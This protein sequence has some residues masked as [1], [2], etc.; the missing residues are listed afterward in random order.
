MLRMLACHGSTRTFGYLTT[1]S[2]QPCRYSYA[3]AIRWADSTSIRRHLPNAASH[4]RFESLQRLQGFPQ[5]QPAECSALP[6]Q[7]CEAD[8][9]LNVLSGPVLGSLAVLTRSATRVTRAYSGPGPKL[10]RPR[11]PKAPRAD[12][13]GSGRGGGANCHARLKCH[14]HPAEACKQNPSCKSVESWELML[15]RFAGSLDLL[16]SDLWVLRVLCGFDV[17]S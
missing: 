11:L 7:P 13:V 8:R 6:L 1:S 16:S 15:S 12:D 9:H 3:L 4:D 14:L 10:S 17:L 5:L 2:T